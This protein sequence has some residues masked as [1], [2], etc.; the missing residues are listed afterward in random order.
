MKLGNLNW[1]RTESTVENI[2]KYPVG[3]VNYTYVCI[4]LIQIH[5]KLFY[6]LTIFYLKLYKGQVFRIF[7][8][9]RYVRNNC[10]L[11]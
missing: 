4:L 6:F 2:H 3:I 9:N 8:L 7:I 10:H 1:T 11:Q 5:I